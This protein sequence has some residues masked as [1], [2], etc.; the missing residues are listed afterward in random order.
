MAIKIYCEFDEFSYE[1]KKIFAYFEDDELERP[2]YE[3]L[4]DDPAS[5]LDN[6]AL[7][8]S[9]I[10]ED[11]NFYIVCDT[12]DEEIAEDLASYLGKPTKIFIEEIHKIFFLVL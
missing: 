7:N 5:D 12:E 1:E 2:D 9:S 8:K 6:L 11:A 4:W 3:D 10:R